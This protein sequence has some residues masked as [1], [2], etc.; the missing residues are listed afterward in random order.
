M[1]KKIIAAAVAATMTSVAIADISITGA[2]KVNYANTD[3]NGTVTNEVRTESN[4]YIT[5]KSGD[6]TVYTEL[7]YDTNSNKTAEADT[8]FAATNLDVEDQ[9]LSTKIGDVAVKVGTWNGSDTIVSA[10]ASRN[11]GRIEAK[12]SFQGFDITIDQEQDVNT[13]GST[14]S[15]N[16]AI[17]TTLGGVS[18]S[19]KKKNAAEEFKF[20]TTVAGV[21]VAYHM[22]DDDA[23]NT[24]KSSLTL[25]TDISGVR[26]EYAQADADSSARITGD[27][28]FGDAAAL[29]VNSTTAGLAAG[30]D[31]S[32][33]KFKSD[34]AGNTVQAVFFSVDDATSGQNDV[35]N[36]KLVVTRPL[37]GGTTLEV[38][39]L[40]TDAS[41][42]A[43]DYEMIDVE[44][45][46]KF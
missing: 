26:V 30:D 15:T 37:A 4:L 45:A 46:V 11:Q 1:N 9:W 32:G 40:S 20:S 24:D 23:A 17:G 13:N 39:Y 10:D 42:S 18:L 44:L 38:V 35:D 2:M 6:T 3:A 29:Y 16:V 43:N 31:I 25:G 12:T 41:A 28:W 8:D 19:A 33:I 7:D 5:G 22:V 21:D 36:T 14:D 34:V 27:S